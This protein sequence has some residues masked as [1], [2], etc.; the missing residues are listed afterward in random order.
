M[1]IPMR[2]FVSRNL[3]A[4]RPF[5]CASIVG[6]S[7]R[8]IHCTMIT[9]LAG[10]RVLDASRFIAGPYCSLL[11]RDYGADVVKVERTRGGDD[12]RTL[13]P[14]VDGESL[15]FMAFNSGKRGITIDFRNPEGQDLLRKLIAQADVFIENFRPGVMAAMGCSYEDL[16]RVNEK[17]VMISI[18]G[19]GQSGPWADRAG[20]D[21]TGQALGGLMSIT[22]WPDGSPTV[23]GTFLV[24]YSTAL[25]ATI[26]CLAAL[27]ARD[28]S[29]S[30]QHIDLA[31]L[32]SAT[33]MLLTFLA[34]FDVNG[35]T[36]GRVGNRDRYSAPI[37]VYEAV[38]GW[39]HVAGGS[40]ALFPLL[41][42][43]L[44]RDEWLTN[45]RWADV[46]S[47]LDHADELEAVVAGWVRDRTVDEVVRHMSQHGVPAAAIA[48]VAD[49]AANPQLQERKMVVPMEHPT[50]GPIRFQGNPLLAATHTG[51][52]RPMAPALGADTDAV[53]KEWLGLSEARIASLRKAGAI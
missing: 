2:C 15:Y 6:P 35:R 52:S 21:V 34:D 4:E 37:N 11:L 25:Y 29:G 7:I 13:P 44:E 45:P 14:I 3:L 53:L 24:D 51:T 50:R 12:A 47:R 30:G 27:R 41:A 1:S 43:A 5:N 31:L 10:V 18:S 38:D 46:T 17:L 26:A 49:V 16:V 9:P 36:A 8:G 23:A 40:D 48:D 20:F 33:S 32:D 19:F 22:G 28:E 42:A 39:V